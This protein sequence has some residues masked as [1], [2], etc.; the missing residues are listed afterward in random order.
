MEQIEMKQM[1]EILLP[2]M[3]ANEPKMERLLADNREIKADNAESKA[4]RKAAKEEMRARI[5]SGQKEM[6]KA[7]M[8]ASQESTEACEEKGEMAINSVP[9]WRGRSMRGWSTPWRLQTDRVRP[10]V[11][12]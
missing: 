7:I 3:D 1:L 8:G 5:R 6:V 11:R 12:S 10:F 2:K 4:E 9:N